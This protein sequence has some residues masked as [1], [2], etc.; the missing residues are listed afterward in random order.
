MDSVLSVFGFIWSWDLKGLVL[1]L[2]IFILVADYFKN[3]QPASF[4]PG[5]MA[6]PVIGNLLS[7]NHKRLHESLVQVGQMFQK[8][9]L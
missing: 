4:P 7:V 6:L 2:V 8:Q 1:F 5:P 9:K 3:R